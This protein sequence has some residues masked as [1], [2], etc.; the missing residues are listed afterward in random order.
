M[1]S[2]KIK[3]NFNLLESSG[4]YDPKLERDACGVGLVA[5]ITGEATHD[6]VTKSLQALCNLEHRGA[7]GADP[8]TG[9]GAGILIQIPHEFLEI[10]AEKINLQLTKG[11]Y[12]TGIIFCGSTLEHQ[13]EIKR[14]FEKCTSDLN[15]DVLGWRDVPTVPKKIGKSAR[16]IMPQI[17][18]VFVGKIDNTKI[19]NIE[20][21]LYLVRKKFEKVISKVFDNDTSQLIYACSLSS[22]KI[23][24]KGLL[25][26][27]QVREFYLDLQNPKV[28]SSFGLV[29]SRFSTNTLGDWKLAHPYRFVAHNGEINTVRGNR[30]WMS[31]REPILNSVNYGKN[32]GELSPIT[33][34][35]DSDT[36]SFDNVFELLNLGGRNLEHTMAMMMPAAW[37]GNETMSQELK[38][39]Y[40]FHSILMEPWDGPALV[41]CTD[42]KKVGAILDRNGLRPFRYT[43]TKDGTLIMGSES[44]LV[45]VDESEIE[46]RE[47]LRPGR[48]FLIDFEEGRIV[49]D[50]E[51]KDSLASF[52]PYSEWLNNN[53]IKSSSLKLIEAQ[54]AK[55]PLINMQ[56]VFGYTQEDLKYLIEP[57]SK[58]SKD[59]VGS[60]G[61][62]APISVLSKKPQNL[63][64]YFKQMF[65]QV[66]NPPLDALRE[67][68]VTQIS[69]PLGRRYNLLE[70]NEKQSSILF[71]DKPILSND[72]MSSIKK[73]NKEGVKPKVISTLIKLDSNNDFDLKKSIENLRAECK[74]AIESDHSILILSDRN[75]KKGYIPIPSL[76]ALS[77]VHHFLIKEGIRS[78][79]DLIVE[80]GEPREVHHFCALFGY[81]ASGVNPYLALETVLNNSDNDKNAADNYIKSAEYGLLKVMSKMGISTLQGYQ[82][83]QIFES[84]GLSKEFV[85][86]YFTWTANKIGGADDRRIKKDMLQNYKAA[87]KETKIPE[88]LELDLGGLYLWRGTGESHMWNPSTISL[89]Q[90]SSTLNDKEKFKEFEKLANNETEDAF[91]LRGLLEFD[92]SKKNSIPIDEVESA[93][94][95]VKRFA[96]GA[97]S[98]GSISKEAHETLAI[99]MNRIGARSNTGEGGEDSKRFKSEKNSRTKQVASGRFGVTADYLVNSTDLQIKMAQGAKPGEGGQ[100]PGS[101]ISEYIGSIRKTTPGVELISPPPHHDIYSI[102]DLAQLIHDLKNINRDARVHV[103]LVSEA[104][105][106]VIAAGVAKAKSD[107]VLISGMSGGTGAAPLGSIRHAGLPWELGLAETNQVLVANGLRGRIVVQTD[108]QMKTG[109]DVAIATLLGAE[110]WGIATAGLIVMGCI[111]LRKC[112]L[113]TCSVGVA[114]QDPE[115]TKLFKGTPE[116]VINYF[117]F[118]AESLREYMSKLGFR[119]INEM[120]GR[121]DMLKVS[122]RA[123]NMP[124][125]SV[126]LGIILARPEVIDGDSSY[127]T[128]EQDHK[129]DKALDFEILKKIN[130]S[131]EDKSIISI[132]QKINNFNRTA[133]TIIS[134]EV[135]KKY[136]EAGLPDE[137]ITINFKGSAGQSF[138]A[139]ACKGLKFNLEGDSND[140]FGKGLSGGKLTVSPN[141]LSTFKPEENIIIGNVALYGA[142]GGMAFI[143][144]VAGERFCVRNSSAIAVVEGIG[145][146]GCEYMTGGTAVIL[147]ETGRNFGAGMSGGIAYVYDKHNN[148]KTKFNSELC[149]LKEVSLNSEDD[150][151]LKSLIN[152]HFEETESPLAKK[153]LEDWLKVITKFKKVTPRD[154]EKALEKLN[155]KH[156]VLIK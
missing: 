102:E 133:G 141:K 97:I 87:F 7:S 42:G 43:V 12:G 101:K 156:E 28:K 140:Y 18:Q 84:L 55:I 30:N 78:G 122:D 9:D 13:K 139:F 45:E 98:L 117:M 147:G 143:N 77:S 3:R 27:E 34:Q 92:Y 127:A 100:I 23:V 137:T 150:K 5:K 118:L 70:E 54:Q 20:Q 25:T 66:S 109:R 119:K 112:H 132:E 149:D 33:N 152:K 146:H 16:E 89:L 10:E 144:G 1:N 26:S 114:T 90:H 37:D 94:E 115:L 73:I 113:N 72:L 82:G 4:S 22:T 135:T 65:A 76:L 52:N 88:E 107:V 19:E 39:F 17:Q 24:Y 29:H 32:I 85:D 64:T 153:M 36:A 155:K 44:G 80:S 105:V 123:K 71:L 129:L 106:G 40:K 116:A 120:I 128:Q 104:G 11:N 8:E 125:A 142:T 21:N 103:K 6:I 95:I 108:G 62:D 148:F 138:G 69:L 93:K 47:R 49:N 60:M 67:K 111:M 86:E 56:Q 2:K 68:L 15:L 50:E 136:G 124:D 81:G 53:S 75:L 79:A 91:T 154:Y 38:D 61:N 110:E 145:D 131:I 99:A 74:K 63:F 126:D 51:I 59:P 96:T 58:S 83:A 31:S 151:I 130:K 46:Y 35:N 41:V 48:M 57:M 14:I 134:S 121:T